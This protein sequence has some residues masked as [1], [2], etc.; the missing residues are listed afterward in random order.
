[1]GSLFYWPISDTE[2]INLWFWWK[3]WKVI[4]TVIAV[5]YVL[6]VSLPSLPISCDCLLFILSCPFSHDQFWKEGIA[7]RQFSHKFESQSD[8]EDKYE[9]TR[10]VIIDLIEITL[11]L[12]RDCIGQGSLQ[13][14]LWICRGMFLV[15]WEGQLRIFIEEGWT[16]QLIYSK[17]NESRPS[18]SGPVKSQEERECGSTWTHHQHSQTMSWDILLNAI[19]PITV[20]IRS[21]CP[22]QDKRWGLLN[23]HNH[24]PSFRI[25]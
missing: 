9:N 23:P 16:V 13:G 3:H 21:R 14:E 15:M 1:M 8:E 12:W 2:I 17:A 19:L 10:M 20:S 18:L 7:T 11:Q 4:K 5:S 22:V 25:L 24:G 6:S